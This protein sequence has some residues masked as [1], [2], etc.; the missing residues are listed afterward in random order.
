MKNIPSA[1][2]LRSIIIPILSLAYLA[3]MVTMGWPS[4]VSGDTSGLLYFGGTALAFACIVAL[5]FHLRG[6]GS[7]ARA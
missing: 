4:Y 1:F 2:H 7:H 3:V 6:C 5:H